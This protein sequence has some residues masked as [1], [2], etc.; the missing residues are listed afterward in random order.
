[1]LKI[2]MRERQNTA[3]LAF[4]VRTHPNPARAG[5][6]KLQTSNFKPQ[7]SNFNFNLKLSS[8]N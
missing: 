3:A 1:M 2:K 6:T 8:V 7:T 5:N 4:S